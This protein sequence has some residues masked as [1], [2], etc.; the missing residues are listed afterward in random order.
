MLLKLK[1]TLDFYLILL[2]V[3]VKRGVM[4]CWI[5]RHFIIKDSSWAYRSFPLLGVRLPPIPCISP[6]S[7]TAELDQISASLQAHFSTSGCGDRDEVFLGTWEGQC[8]IP[9]YLPWDS[10]ILSCWEN[11]TLTSVV[12][13]ITKSPSALSGSVNKEQ[14]HRALSKNAFLSIMV[15]LYFSS[16]SLAMLKGKSIN[17]QEN[18]CYIPVWE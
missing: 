7:F 6:P 5:Q 1:K 9:V 13:C 14:L 18:A 10:V 4:I 12:Q 11:Q 17:L 15:L 16:F 3:E 8:W 2:N